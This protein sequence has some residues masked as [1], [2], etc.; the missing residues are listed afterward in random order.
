MDFS[1]QPIVNL[2]MIHEHPGWR[3]VLM[4]RLSGIF[5]ISERLL[6]RILRLDL[7]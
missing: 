3:V 7:R 4:R 2:M 1:D 5:N 6:T